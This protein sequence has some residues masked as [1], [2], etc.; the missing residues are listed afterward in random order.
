MVGGLGVATTPCP[1][2]LVICLVFNLILIVKFYGV[3]FAK[4]SSILISIKKL[5][6]EMFD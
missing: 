3:F 1:R 6:Q 2:R 5:E 4:Y